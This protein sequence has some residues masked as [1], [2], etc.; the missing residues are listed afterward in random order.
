M[1]VRVRPAALREL[2]KLR[3]DIKL[4]Q[5]RTFAICMLEVTYVYGGVIGPLEQ[6]VHSKWPPAVCGLPEL[7]A[8]AS[9]A[10]HIKYVRFHND[11]L[12]VFE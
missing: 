11:A 12:Y 1:R 3:A 5:I 2:T 6:R 8:E 9:L 4:C 10:Y 7:R